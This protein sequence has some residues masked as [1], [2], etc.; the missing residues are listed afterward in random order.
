M[1]KTLLILLL[2]V[3][4]F[5]ITGCSNEENEQ[6]DQDVDIRFIDEIS[7][8]TPDEITYKFTGVSEH[9]ALQT[10]K[11]YYGDNNERYMLFSNLKMIKKIDNEDDIIKYKIDL[12]FNDDSMFSPE[13]DTLKR[14]S[15]E[16][17]IKS[18][19]VEESGIYPEDGYGEFDAFDLTTK[20]NFKDAIKFEITYCYSD[21]TCKTEN[22]KFNYIEN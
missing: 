11:V 10:G 8:L 6:D 5:T 2:F 4:F 9:F 1:R 16:E 12:K 18:F 22:L 3:S 7:L 19:H 20:D 21:E 17:R 13:M 14:N 15:F